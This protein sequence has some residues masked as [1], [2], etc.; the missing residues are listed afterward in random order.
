MICDSGR[1]ES[2]LNRT[3]TRGRAGAGNVARRHCESDQRGDNSIERSLCV[4]EFFF[5]GGVDHL[6]IAVAQKPDTGHPRLLAYGAALIGRSL[7][8]GEAGRVSA[9]LEA[10]CVVANHSGVVG[11]EALWSRRLD[12]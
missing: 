3:V 9:E 1:R 11:I 12:L 5:S 10:L 4:P 8:L 2:L 7:V 6:D